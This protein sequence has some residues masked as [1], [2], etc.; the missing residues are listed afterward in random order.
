M[1]EE[2]VPMLEYDHKRFSVG[3]DPDGEILVIRL[4]PSGKHDACSLD[5]AIKA[6][7]VKRVDAPLWDES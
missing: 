6:G 4:R 5:D 3:R 7:W 1:G 2:P